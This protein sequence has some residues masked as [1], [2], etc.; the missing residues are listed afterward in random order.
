MSKKIEQFAS[1]KL[2]IW[3]KFKFFKLVFDINKYH[4]VTVFIKAERERALLGPSELS[5]KWLASDA[6]RLA[7]VVRHG[8]LKSSCASYIE[9][10]LGHLVSGIV[11]FAD[12]NNNLDFL[13]SDV[14]ASKPVWLTNLWISMFADEQI[15][16]LN[17][18][19]HFVQRAANNAAG[20]G[21]ERTEFVCLQTSKQLL[22][23]TTSDKR[24]LG[25]Q[26]PF[27]WLI[28]Q[29]LDELVYLK[30]ESQGISK[31]ATIVEE[32]RNFKEKSGYRH[33]LI[34]FSCNYKFPI[35]IFV[36]VVFC[37]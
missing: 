24:A 22:N 13:V 31:P 17:Y 1:N 9:Q 19:T 2:K 32:P 29:F 18:N 6:S 33:N 7:Q 11:A 16:Q 30:I 12:T 8:T 28:K 5:R 10:R 21:K 4:I 3:P 25:L 20:S 37:I 23:M 34:I 26:L 35:L 27:S 15:T 14:D 36:S